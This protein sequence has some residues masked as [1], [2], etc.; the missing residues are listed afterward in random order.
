[1]LLSLSGCGAPGRIELM[2][3]PGPRSPQF[4]LQGSCAP[5]SVS[6]A[7]ALNQLTSSC[8]RPLSAP[9]LIETAADFDA[10][11]DVNC[12]KPSIDFSV[13]RVLIVPARGAQEWFVFPNFVGE[14]SDALEVGLVTRPQGALPP[15]T[16]VLLPQTPS[17]VELRWCHSVC[18]KNC[19][20]AIP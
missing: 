3:D 4:S 1:M 6:T 10:L 20:V 17:R 8:V 15:D 11:F 12:D 5:S 2:E 9:A 7:R 19:D 13:T 16:L 14:R 18:V